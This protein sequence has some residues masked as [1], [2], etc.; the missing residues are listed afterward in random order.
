M[1]RTMIYSSLICVVT[2]HAFG[3]GGWAE[4][5]AATGIVVNSYFSPLVQSSAGMRYQQVETSAALVNLCFLLI[6]IAI[7]SEK[8]WPFRRSRA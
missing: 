2:I 4:K 3:R 1:W 5:L 6:L 8:F 7:G